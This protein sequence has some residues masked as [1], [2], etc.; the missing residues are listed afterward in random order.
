MWS[1]KQLAE[2]MRYGDIVDLPF[3]VVDPKLS[4]NEVHE[5]AEEYL[6]RINEL[7][8][9][10]VLVQGEMTLTFQLVQMLKDKGIKVVAACTERQT[11]DYSDGKITVFEFAGYREY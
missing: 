11:E 3:P 10:I 5:L 9:A 7:D 1:E 2:S 4:K 8:P 6:A